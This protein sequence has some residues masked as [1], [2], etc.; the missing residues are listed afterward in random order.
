[1]VDF[2]TPNPGNAFLTDSSQADGISNATAG[3]VAAQDEICQRSGQKVP[4]GSLRREWTGLQVRGRSWEARHPLDLIR[5]RAAERGRGSPSP[6]PSDQFVKTTYLPQR[7]QFLPAAS[8]GVVPG[9]GFG[10]WMQVVDASPPAISLPVTMTSFLVAVRA[11][12]GRGNK[13]RVFT[14]SNRTSGGIGRFN[15]TF[16]PFQYREQGH[17]RITCNSSFAPTVLQFIIGQQL[18]PIGSTPAAPESGDL[19]PCDKDL[20]IVV[21]GDG[22]TGR[23]EAWHYD[24]EAALF[25]E[26]LTGEVLSTDF[27]RL[28]SAEARV[29]PTPGMPVADAEVAAL[30]GTG[31]D[32]NNTLG[33]GAETPLLSD[34][35]CMQM[36]LF[37]F[38][39]S[40]SSDAFRDLNDSAV[41][42]ALLGSPS[43]W[44]YSAP[45]M[46]L[47]HEAPAATFT[48]NKAPGQSS[49]LTYCG[50]NATYAAAA[51]G[52]T[53]CEPDSI[54]P[55]VQE[56]FFVDQ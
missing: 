49:L 48:V 43:G 7:V 29:L 6:E 3:S 40:S 9:D 37:V 54:N 52:F 25:H 21:T 23:L 39:A 22:A 10:D 47:W 42:S 27:W 55:Y 1:M 51:G 20:M 2:L 31:T 26:S 34:Y 5:S 44:G 53:D 8:N 41:R 24:Y 16:S 30:G 11:R 17:F 13:Q 33:F 18:N 38:A 28:N 15:L 36:A 50:G 14:M 45:V 46:R 56:L 19:L 12:V 35:C 4:R 32:F